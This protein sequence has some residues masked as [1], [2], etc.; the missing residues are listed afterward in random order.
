MHRSRKKTGALHIGKYCLRLA[1]ATLPSIGIGL[2]AHALFARYLSY[3]AAFA[4]SMLVIAAAELI[5][6]SLLRLLDLRALLLRFFAKK[7]KKISVRS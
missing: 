3:F 5:F 7:R 6:F 4:L 2:A 1:G